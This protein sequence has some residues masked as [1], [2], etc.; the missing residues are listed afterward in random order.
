M[1]MRANIDQIQVLDCMFTKS[2]IHFQTF[3]SEVGLLVNLLQTTIED[4]TL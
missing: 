3:Y 1:E 2:N 4:L